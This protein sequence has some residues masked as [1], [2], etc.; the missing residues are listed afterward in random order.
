MGNIFTSKL[1]TVEN[2]L[3]ND[4]VTLCKKIG[5]CPL[6]IN[7]SKLNELNVD[8]KELSDKIAL[9]RGIISLK[10]KA[11]N[12]RVTTFKDV[13]IFFAAKINAELYSSLSQLIS[14]KQ[15]N[16]QKN[17]PIVLYIF[18]NSGGR[19]ELEFDEVTYTQC[20]Q[21]TGGNIV[22]VELF[23]GE[24]QFAEAPFFGKFRSGLNLNTPNDYPMNIRFYH[25]DNRVSNIKENQE[26][27]KQL[28]NLISLALNNTT[29]Q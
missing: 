10:N 22:I 15:I 2:D 13:P 26:S 20:Y 7:E 24:P 19:A 29:A 3:Q 1:S 21:I 25:K 11:D 23:Y 27:L 5:S 16:F 8:S 4:I 14:T 17:Y 28:Q 18:P 6:S 9:L 12:V